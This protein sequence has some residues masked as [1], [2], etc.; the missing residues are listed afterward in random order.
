MKL[1]ILHLRQHALLATLL[2]AVTPTATGQVAALNL[3]RGVNAV[4]V[5]WHGGH[6]PFLVETATDSGHWSAQGDPVA[7]TSLTLPGFASRAM[8]RIVDLD[9]DD[10]QGSLLGLI[11]TDQGE[12]GPLLGRHRLKT[13]LWLYSTKGPPHTSPTF[14]AADYF[15][16][17]IVVRQYLEA[18]RVRTWTGALES[19]GT[20]AT[21]S[22]SR[23]TVTWSDGAGETRR[24]FVLSLTFP[25]PLANSR[26]TAPLASDPRY[27][28]SCTYATP[29][30]E[31]DYDD[32]GMILTQTTRQETTALYQLDPKNG[33]SPF[34][35]PRQYTVSD[36]GAQVNLHFLEGVPLLEGSPP[37]I[38]KTYIL[39]RWLS[40]STG[41]G[42]LP[43][44]STDS[45]FAR[46]LHPGHHN[47]VETVLLEP[48]L[49][50]AVAD[51][52][53]TTLQAA[54]IRYIYTFKDLDI[55]VNTDDIR[56]VGFDNH[57]RD[58]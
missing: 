8:Y 56:Y 20:V 55:G 29:Q 32:S 23:M 14:T 28:L 17:L 18:G 6:G 12:F 39:D 24:T 3:T 7:G 47:F 15:R 48:A 58:P 2:A 1:P 57:L 10:R 36:S 44:F 52:T 19:L 26:T 5:N 21:P 4:T 50:P 37:F 42:S 46:T 41:S 51:T 25:Y 34:P 40:P 43:G 27:E 16:T 30:P 11:Q 45:W 38:W 54:N 53:R 35:A 9:A 33:T 22:N 13:R 31:F 49:D